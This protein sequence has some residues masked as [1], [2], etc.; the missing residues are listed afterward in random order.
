[1]DTFRSVGDVCTL[2]PMLHEYS[3]ML[4][5]GD[6]IEQ[7]EAA[8]REARDVCESF[9]L[10][11]W[12]SSTS[13]RLASLALLRGDHE[14]AAA[15]YRAAADLAHELAS[16]HAELAALEGLA[17]A[18]EHTGDEAAAVRYREAARVIAVQLGLGVDEP[19]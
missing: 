11:G 9:G 14:A 18:H 19:V 13:G 3:R 1:I 5:A 15:H 10:R 4:Q 12:Q 8:V 6:R 17:L 16:P 2:V 7:A